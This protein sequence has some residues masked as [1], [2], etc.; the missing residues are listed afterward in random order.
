VNCQQVEAHLTMMMI[1]F[2]ITLRKNT[3]V[4]AFESV[5]SF[6]TWNRVVSSIVCV[7]CPL[8]MMNN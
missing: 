5:S 4:I 7:V 6:F 8:A 3:V 2:I 1:V